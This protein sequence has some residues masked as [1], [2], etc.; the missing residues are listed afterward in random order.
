MDHVESYQKP[1]LGSKSNS[2]QMAS[3]VLENERPTVDQ[4]EESSMF[5][6][7]TS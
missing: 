2:G 7:V 5:V 4:Y 1:Y 6:N 3:M